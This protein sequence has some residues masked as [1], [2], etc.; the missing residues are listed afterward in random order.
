MAVTDADKQTAATEIAGS[1]DQ[2]IAAAE[3]TGRFPV[4]VRVLRRM[5][6][7]PFWCR[8]LLLVVATDG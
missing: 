7:S 3:A 6:R 4:R 1:I 8:C 2:W 5:R